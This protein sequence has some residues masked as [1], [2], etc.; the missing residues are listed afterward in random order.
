MFAAEASNQASQMADVQEAVIDDLVEAARRVNLS[1]VDIVAGV[2]TLAEREIEIANGLTMITKA[3]VVLNASSG[4]STRVGR[5]EST[6]SVPP[7]TLKQLQNGTAPL[8]VSFGVYPDTTDEFKAFEAGSDALLVAGEV[9]SIVITGLDGKP[10][11]GRLPEPIEI[12][13]STKVFHRRNKCVFWDE[14]LNDWSTEGVSMVDVTNRST[15]CLT[16]HLSVFSLVLA[17]LSCNNAAL[18][19]SQDAL[20]AL[21]STS[22]AW[23]PP[24]VVNWATLLLGCFLIHKARLADRRYEAQMRRLQLWANECHEAEA[25]N[26]FEQIMQMLGMIGQCRT[27]LRSGLKSVADYTYSLVIQ[28]KYGVNTKYLEKLHRGIGKTQVHRQAHEEVQ[29]FRSDSCKHQ[30]LILFS[31]FCRWTNILAPSWQLA[32][33]DR[34]LLL[35]AK[36]Y[37]T[38]A[39][40]AFFF[41]TTSTAPDQ[42]PDC[43]PQEEFWAML[44]QSTTVAWVSA[45]FASL[46]LLCLM[47]VK[48]AVG[49]TSSAARITFRTFTVAYAMFCLVTTCLFLAA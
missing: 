8:A 42:D 24:A 14:E 37:S 38:W 5:S 25:F 49:M 31:G 16:T 48:K 26:P 46:P 28:N 41:G 11:K 12:E 33:L 20:V 35:F 1:E 45:V 7:N 44:V 6:V 15:R 47:L 13:L 43:E 36:L 39:L 23:Q 10:F 17:A 3:L 18:I 22:W 40:C 27:L 9:I 34:C 21:V 32:S 30:F 19:F 2:A 4:L 29:H